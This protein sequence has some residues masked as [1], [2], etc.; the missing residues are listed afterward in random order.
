M[1]AELLLL[2]LLLWFGL[3]CPMCRFVVS[4]EPGLA[5]PCALGLV[6]IA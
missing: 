5:C 3:D 4:F 6:A 1:P 2:L